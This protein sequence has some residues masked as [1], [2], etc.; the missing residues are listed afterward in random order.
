MAHY[1]DILDDRHFRLATVDRGIHPDTGDRIPNVTLETHSLSGA[2]DIGYNALSY[3]WGSPR[4]LTEDHAK[5]CILLNGKAIEVQTN[6]YDALVELQV[7][8]KEIPI[9]IDALCINQSSDTERSAQVS[10]MNLIYGKASKVIVWLGKAYPELEAGIKA[11]ERIG[12]ESVPHTLR[13]LGMQT[14]DFTSEMS[15]MPERYNMDPITEEEVIGLIHLFSSKW[16][17]RVWVIQ[18]ISLARDVAVLCDG[19]FTPFDCVGL[20][21]T[22]IHYSGLIL[23]FLQYFPRNHPV[24]ELLPSVSI[25]Q[26]ERLQLLREWCKGEASLWRDVLS[27]I[28]FEAGLSHHENSVSLLMLRLLYS[29]FGFEASDPR[30]IIYGLGGILKHMASEQG[31]SIPT[32]FEPDYTIGVGDLFQNV[33]RKIMETTDSLVLLTLAMESSKREIRGLSSWTMNYSTLMCNSIHGPQFKSV[34]AFDASKHAPTLTSDRH[35]VIDGNTLNVTGL[36]LGT[37]QKTAE[38]FEESY[39]GGFDRL[40]DLLLD[41]ELTYPY[42]NQPADEALWRTL[43]W[44][45]DLSNRPS[46]PLNNESLQRV[47]WKQ[48]TLA[49]KYQSMAQA[50]KSVAEK[51]AST[52]IDKIAYLDK[53]VAKYPSSFFPSVKLVKSACVKEG[54]IKPEEGEDLVDDEELE[55]LETSWTKN[56]MPPHVLLTI[57]W[58][59]RRPFLTD[60]GY[61]GLGYSSTAVGD[62]LWIVSGSPAPLVLRKTGSSDNE[63]NVVGEAYVHGAMHGEAI[64]HGVT[65][66][67]LQIV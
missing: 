63:Y 22:F 48:I 5:Q 66:K 4:V 24:A 54:L 53:V 29:T 59:G 62:E 12:T 18:E 38:D 36:Y 51:L 39:Q 17:T 61:L 20:T 11:A 37:V 21:A 32:E 31:L 26:S 60:T 42:T 15:L 47:I 49:L 64:D 16:F 9:W 46:K 2:T 27:M 34:G 56:T 67:R 30:D 19:K 45:N 8:T 14:W 3:T 1:L 55:R 33:S 65:W 43:I 25:Y 52:C 6:L 13:M 28:D 50:D 41:M 57:S 7:S 58:L 23:P 35:F 44:D 10:V 40:A